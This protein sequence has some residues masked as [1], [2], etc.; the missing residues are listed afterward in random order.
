LAEKSELFDLFI[1][2][3]GSLQKNLDSCT[4][5]CLG[6]YFELLLKLNDFLKNI[7]CALDCE[8]LRVWSDNAAYLLYNCLTI[9]LTQQSQ[10]KGE[11]LCD[12]L[13]VWVIGASSF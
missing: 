2:F 9:F 1:L 11:S 13:P 10:I 5:C 3:A 7:E 8:G 6:G 12:D 4:Y